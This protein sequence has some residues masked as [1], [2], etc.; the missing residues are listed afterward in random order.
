MYARSHSPLFSTN[1]LPSLTSQ[2]NYS[3]AKEY[4]QKNP[5]SIYQRYGRS[6]R[7]V[8][9]E[10]AKLVSFLPSSEVDGEL[11]DADEDE[12]LEQSV[13]SFE[14]NTS[15]TNFVEATGQNGQP[16]MVPSPMAKRPASCQDC[17]RDENQRMYDLAKVMIDV[18][19]DLGPITVPAAPVEETIAH[20]RVHQNNNHR[21]NEN[22]NNHRN[23]DEGQQNDNP[24]PPADAAGADADAAAPPPE[25]PD[26]RILPVDD[27]DVNEEVETRPPEIHESILTVTDSFGKTPL[28]V[29]CENTADIAMMKVLFGCTRDHTSHPSAPMAFSLIV[30]KDHNDS[31]PLHYLAYSRNCPFSSLQLAM[32][33]ARPIPEFDPSLCTDVD[34]DTPLHWAL[35]GY[36]SPRRVQQLLRYNK[37]ALWVKS[38]SGCTP[39]DQFVENFVDS[40]WQEHELLG[41]EIWENIQGYLKVLYD[42]YQRDDFHAA[43]SETAS[44][45]EFLPLHM[46]C[47]SSI[48]FPPVFLDIALHYLKD[49]LSKPNANGMLPLHLACS[50]QERYSRNQPDTHPSKVAA[51]LVSAHPQSA[52]KRSLRTNQLAIHLAIESRKPLKLIAVLLRAYPH[53]LNVPD[54]QTGLWPFLLAGSMSSDFDESDTFSIEIS[55]GLLRADP[56]ILQVTLKALQKSH[57][58]QQANIDDGD[59]VEVESRSLRRLRI[60]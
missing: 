50:R 46:I 39:L 15:A 18:S 47:G 58:E 21:H 59:D 37:D 11:S 22:A 4:I 57:R 41:K 14:G 8:I 1:L 38:H 20:P 51:R 28:H 53:S 44:A 60:D 27:L 55:Y 12:E 6:H 26:Q 52:Y 33:Y 35:D 31:T 42:E 13:N 17:L 19:H 2:K 29:L 45:S 34:G 16:V 54:P 36:M 40:D 43:A 32:D 5:E 25:D 23:G 9:H 49:H 48:D 24:E 7:L 56:S 3:A 30:A 10:L